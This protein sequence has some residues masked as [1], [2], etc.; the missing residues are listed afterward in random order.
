M[1]LLLLLLLRTILELLVTR[2]E[3]LRIARQVRLRLRFSRRVAR[4]VL[5]HVRLA[6]I[7]VAVKAFIGGALR[8]SALATLLRLL[9][10]VGVLLTE[11]FLCGSDQAEIVFG[12]LIIILGRDRIAGT[13]RIACKLDIFFRNM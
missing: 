1:G 8:L 13:L 12:M 4:L 7:V 3:R 9:I 2:R 11:L 5:P 10:V 6:V